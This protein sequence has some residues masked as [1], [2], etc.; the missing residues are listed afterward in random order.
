[1]ATSMMEVIDTLKP[2]SGLLY[3]LGEPRDHRFW[4]SRRWAVGIPEM[5]GPTMALWDFESIDSGQVPTATGINLPWV[6]GNMAFDD[7]GGDCRCRSLVMARNTPQGRGDD[8]IVVDLEATVEE[9]RLIWSASYTTSFIKRGCK[10]IDIWCWG[11]KTY[12]TA[13]KEEGIL[14]CLTTGQRIELTDRGCVAS[15]IGGEFFVTKV[16]D[17]QE[18]GTPGGIAFWSWAGG[19]AVETKRC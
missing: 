16:A 8:V 18:C 15:P 10:I 12:A 19:E 14:F 11:G 3:T 7:D 4:I 13:E 17:R 1:M 2:T 9:R 5:L 6:V